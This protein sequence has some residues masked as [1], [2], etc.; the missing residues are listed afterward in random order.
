MMNNMKVFGH[1]CN[2]WAVV[3]G[4][5]DVVVDITEI[6]ESY[7]VTPEVGHSYYFDGVTWEVT[8]IRGCITLDE[9]EAEAV[10]SEDDYEEEID[11]VLGL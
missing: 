8:D 5:H 6:F 3:A 9:I 2:F 11:Q 7:G 10:D 1:R 4:I